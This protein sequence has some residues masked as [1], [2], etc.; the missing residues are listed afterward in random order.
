MDKNL[1]VAWPGETPKTKPSL[2]TVAIALLLDVQTPPD[3]GDKEV[4]FP[5]QI[6]EGPDTDTI[7]NGLTV[8]ICEES[9]EQPVEV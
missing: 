5:A 2:L 1:N 9:E 6:D 3:I 7:G 4:V 8:I